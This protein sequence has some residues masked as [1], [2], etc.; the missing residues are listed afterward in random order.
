VITHF[1]GAKTGFADV[2]GQSNPFYPVLV[3]I[4]LHGQYLKN[5]QHFIHVVGLYIKHCPGV[6]QRLSTMVS[7]PLFVTLG[8]KSLHIIQ[9]NAKSCLWCRHDVTCALLDF[10]FG[11]SASFHKLQ[12]GQSKTLCGLLQQQQQQPSPRPCSE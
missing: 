3:T 4:T 2:D 5:L 11:G 7:W 1:Y 9:G 10:E 12:K 8:G 6:V